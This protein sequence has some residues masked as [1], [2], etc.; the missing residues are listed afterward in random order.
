M[1][2]D[3][4]YDYCYLW[5]NHKRHTVPDM[6]DEMYILV[7]IGEFLEYSMSYGNKGNLYSFHF[8]LLLLIEQVPVT[9]SGITRRHCLVVSKP[10]N[11]SFL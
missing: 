9:E 5:I 1:C 6:T 2:Y 10:L 7:Y 11:I 3:Y 4:T 8:I